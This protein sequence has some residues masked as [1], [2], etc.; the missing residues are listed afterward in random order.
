MASRISSYE[1][2]EGA[3]T[4]YVRHDGEDRW[5]IRGG[6]IDVLVQNGHGTLDGTVFT[7]AEAAQTAASDVLIALNTFLDTA[8]TLAVNG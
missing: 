4:V 5:I 8:D 2:T 7:T 6:V 1:V 3:Q